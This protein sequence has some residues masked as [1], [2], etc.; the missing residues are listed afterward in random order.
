MSTWYRNAG[1]NRIYHAARSN[2][3]QS[4]RALCGASIRFPAFVARDKVEVSNYARCRPCEHC[5]RREGK[6]R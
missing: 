6:K 3:I 5:R 1:R 4:G 2:W